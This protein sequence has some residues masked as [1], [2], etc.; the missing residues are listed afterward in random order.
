M[1]IES[2][3]RETLM[4]QHRIKDL[5]FYDSELKWKVLE[6]GDCCLKFFIQSTVLKEKTNN[7]VDQIN[8]LIKLFTAPQRK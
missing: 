6:F 1:I 4:E 3:L 7:T 5:L 2:P 8:A